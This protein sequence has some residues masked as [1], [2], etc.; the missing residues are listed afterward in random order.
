MEIAL[1]ETAAEVAARAAV[2]DVTSEISSL[3]R[4][5]RRAAWAG[6]L[7]VLPAVAMLVFVVLAISDFGGGGSAGG[8]AATLS[9]GHVPWFGRAHDEPSLAAV[10]GERGDSDPW[11]QI[12]SPRNRFLAIAA[13]VALLLLV[14]GCVARCI[15]ARQAQDLEERVDTM[16]AAHNDALSAAHC[17]AFASD[18]VALGGQALFV[19][20]PS[21]KATPRPVTPPKRSRCLSDVHGNRV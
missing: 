21:D 11:W 5:R 2:S 10:V 17:E 14:V 19:P 1:E 9:A 18:K 15:L 8:S 3:A 12:R 4:V 6:K 20:A 16:L 7:T 13:G